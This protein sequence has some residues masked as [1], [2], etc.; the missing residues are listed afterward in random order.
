M[1]GDVESAKRNMEGAPLPLLLLLLLSAGDDAGGVR[2]LVEQDKA[3]KLRWFFLKK[4]PNRFLRCKHS[5]WVFK[6]FP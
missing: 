2:R 1:S 5:T 4:F 6:A 3:T